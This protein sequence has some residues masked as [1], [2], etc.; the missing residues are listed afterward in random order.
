MRVIA[1][2]AVLM[3]CTT[4]FAD[5]SFYFVAGV[6]YVDPRLEAQKLQ[7]NTSGL[8]SIVGVTVPTLADSGVA[9]DPATIPAGISGYTLPWR[10]RRLST[11]TMIGVPMTMK[12]KATG[13]LA[14]ESLAPM[15]FGFIPTGIPP[16]GSELGEA[17]AVPP[18]I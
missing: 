17:N 5:D 14:N 1:T 12:L 16:L 13:K 2:A 10:D 15:A 8:A 4:A 18:M 11:E 3:T 9:V 6:T 7:V